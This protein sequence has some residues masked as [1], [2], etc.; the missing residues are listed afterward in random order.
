VFTKAREEKVAEKTV[1]IIGAGI[2]GLSTGCYGQMNSY[3]TS[4]F[5][6]HE[7][8]GGLCTS[9]KRKGY[10][11][12]GCIHWIM[13]TRPGTAHHRIW[14]E[15]GAVQ[16]REMVYFDEYARV[17]GTDGKT[18]IVHKDIDQ[19]EQH[20]KQLAPE[21][22]KVIDG[23]IKAIRKFSGFEMPVGIA[24]EIM[25]PIQ[26][27]KMMVHMLPYMRTFMKWK[28]MSLG[29]F[30][31]RFRNPFMR[32][33]IPT[34][35][36][37]EGDYFP[38]ICAVMPLAQNY[39]NSIGYPTGGSLEFSQ[40]IEKRYKEL[41]GSVHYHTKVKKILVRN[42]QAV[43]IQLENRD[44]Y[45]ADYV[46][47]TADGHSTI[48]D[49]LD[50]KY[51]NAKIKGYYDDLPLFP[52]L[53]HIAL[54]V[55]LSFKN[56]PPTPFGT[57]YLLE[58]PIDIAGKQ[59]SYLKGV[60]CYNFDPT[61]APDGKTVIVTWFPTEYDYWKSLEKDPVRYKSEKN[62]VAATIIKLLD[63][64]IPGLAEKVEMID[65]ATPGTYE[66]YTGAWKA[67]FEGWN[68]NTK[69]FGMRMS[70]SLP[71]L[72]NFYMAGQWV[73]PGGSVFFVAVSGRNVIQIMCKKDGKPFIT[74]IE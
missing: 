34:C 48:F 44:E 61:L 36:G 10:T 38:A 67:S 25:N 65:V 53:V 74:R 4:I 14:E 47:S 2:A 32:K 60:R 68:M 7:R 29:D 17:I 64:R 30:A 73:E 20:M 6:M 69:T 42:N 15:L 35:F 33:I 21:D 31:D 11:I 41:G 26:G 49:M 55:N 70:K 22:E 54:G 12:N 59:L 37:L 39:S 24:P 66:R 9:W 63:K 28:R 62:K 72:R 19:L 46:V 58:K 13:G 16:E 43:G 45:L 52:P 40:A 71:R 57:N 8:A 1:I 50:G 56:L 51:L 18:F 3:K 23:Y 27:L 5:E